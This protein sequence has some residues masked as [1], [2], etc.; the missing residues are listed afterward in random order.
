LED[1]SRKSLLAFA[2]FRPIFRAQPSAYQNRY[3]ANANT[4]R[5]QHLE[6]FEPDDLLNHS[7]VFEESLSWDLALFIKTAARALEA[8]KIGPEE[9]ESSVK[10]FCT[11]YLPAKLPTQRELYAALLELTEKHPEVLHTALAHLL[12]KCELSKIVAGDFSSYPRFGKT[13]GILPL[14]QRQE[15][16]DS[17]LKHL[18]GR[19]GAWVQLLLLLIDDV[20]KDIELS[21]N[22]RIVGDLADL[23]FQ[24]ARE[25]WVETVDT[26]LNIVRFLEPAQQQDYIDRAIDV[27]LGLSAEGED[28][29]RM[30]PFLR[31]ASSFPGHVTG[32]TA[33]KTTKFVHRMLG[34]A[35]SET[36][37]L[38]TLQFVSTLDATA[39]TSLKTEIE[40]LAAASEPKVSEVAK[41]L[42]QKTL[43]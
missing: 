22:A 40:P 35:K 19:K 31:L 43:G 32:P 21:K 36:A 29:P 34:A 14:E 33:A 17:V 26:L 3:G 2:P 41:E 6:V 18:E 1:D 8:K 15:F 38:R 27:L 37:K 20:T 24:A 28:L 9:L 23:S 25:K 39:L 10:T 42:L 30:E 12:A 11:K 5:Q 13:K 7:D 4:Y 16:I